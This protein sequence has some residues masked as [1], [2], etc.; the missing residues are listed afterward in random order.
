MQLLDSFFFGAGSETLVTR[1]Q[2]PVYVIWSFTKELI[3]RTLQKDAN[4]YTQLTLKMSEKLACMMPIFL[5]SIKSS[6]HTLFKGKKLFT[7]KI[8][9]SF[10]NIIFFSVFFFS[11]YT[12][13]KSKCAA[14]A[15]WIPNKRLIELI[16]LK[17]FSRENLI[18][19]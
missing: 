12:L 1:V 4:I 10:K 7:C 11:M 14:L 18:I 8:C 15:W 5:G 9:F 16:G 2:V 13:L 17:K 19:V 6:M 3:T